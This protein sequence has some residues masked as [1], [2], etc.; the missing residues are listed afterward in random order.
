VTARGV[1]A[2]VA[3]VAGFATA[4]W[5]SS[6]PSSPSPLGVEVV[7]VI[8]AATAPVVVAEVES[9]WA[10]MVGLVPSSSTAPPFRLTV[11]PAF[12]LPPQVL[13]R[14]S[15]GTIEVR[16]LPSLSTSLDLATRL[17]LR[18]EVVHQ[19]LWR[20]CAPS[21]R[22][23]LFH[24]AVAV[25]LSG[26][27]ALWRDGAYL[28]V[29]AAARALAVADLDT[30]SARRALARLVSEGG[31]PLPA[32]LTERLVRCADDAPWSPLRV[33]DLASGDRHAG[34]DALVVLH[35]QSG[36]VLEATG[37]VD[38]PQPFGSTLKPF[39]VAAALAA[40]RSLPTF[41]AEARDPQ[42]A[43]GE[44]L[45]A[46]V[47]VATALQRS[48]NGWFLALEQQ[49][50]PRAVDLGDVGEVL[51]RLGLSRLPA[52]MSEGIGIRTGPT[53]SARALAEAWRTLALATPTPG[54]L[55]IMAALRTRGTLLGVE[56]IAGLDGM[57]AKTGTVRDVRS[58]P[59]LGLLVAADDELVIVRVRAGVQARALV[60]DVVA[61][62]RRHAGRHHETARVQVFGLL[63]EHAV[64][65]RCDG[66]AVVI[67]AVPHVATSTSLSSLVA[68]GRA[69]CTG[70][71]WLVTPGRD[72]AERP[73]A[74]VFHRSPAPPSPST[75]PT[76]TP[77]QRA[78]RRGSD[79]VFSTSR[80]RYVDGVLR[81][82]DSTLRGEARV[83]L[84]RVID[85]DHDHGGERHPGR[86]V[87]DTTHCMTFKGTTSSP[88]DRALVDAL[89]RPLVDS[90]R[91]G[92]LPFSQGGASPW[93]ETRPHR[94]VTAALGAFA[95]LTLHDGADGGRVVVVV[96]AE[97]V[98]DAD[99]DEPEAVPCEL[100]RSRL[101][102]PSCPT[103]A[104]R[105]GDRWT[106]SGQ[107]AGHG[108]GLD[109]E[110]AKRRA[111]GGASADAILD[112]AFPRQRR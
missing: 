99:I 17:A 61:A 32:A 10:A 44:G 75:D 11:R 105:T 84:S 102:L 46:R 3:A 91:R 59:T 103:L 1:V 8:D 86:P 33:E 14:S 27:A 12:S 55:D 57:A 79:V 110:Q 98:G 19:F 34:Q 38:L 48:C 65:A 5:S 82:E 49:Q 47:D 50:G 28:S 72:L 97:R 96:R 40:G 94:A 9:A 52:D 21:T 64:E 6:P 68:R 24:E 76:A 106:F 20:R 71:P 93:Q 58:R 83:A 81:A 108:L 88:P 100:L 80:S 54:G 25:A 95:S 18:H 22:D 77:R 66:T 92:W 62:R 41:P 30:P 36:E 73:Y 70:G 42:W 89:Q 4:G 39:I 7:A 78:A 111:R 53:L 26:E 31:G 90:G 74:G 60:D 112:E 69:V 101:R 63:P 37:A 43:C 15:P 35:T 87:C 51:L 2:V 16:S 45:P 67:D 109:V 23:R 13:A 85:H 107:G 56:G 29:P 104:T